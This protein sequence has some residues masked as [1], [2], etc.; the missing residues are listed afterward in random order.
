MDVLAS[1]YEMVYKNPD[2]FPNRFGYKTDE[3][4]L[5]AGYEKSRCVA[6]DLEAI[7]NAFN[8]PDICHLCKV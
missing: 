4:K 5:S 6:K 3:E 7:K 1:L 8:Y 2:A